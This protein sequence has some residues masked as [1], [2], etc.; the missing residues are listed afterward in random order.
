MAEADETRRDFLNRLAAG[1]WALSVAPACAPPARS[2]GFDASRLPSAEDVWDWQLWM[3]SLG[4]RYTGGEAHATFVE[5]LARSL[6]ETGL[7]VR[8]DGFRFTR[9][10]AR[11]WAL[12]VSDGSGGGMVETPVASYYP[13]SGLTP[14]GGV[15]GDLVY[16]GR[17]PDLSVPSDVAGKI[18]Y[19]ESPTPSLDFARWYAE[20]GALPGAAGLPDR[21]KSAAAQTLSA[22]DLRPFAEAGAAGVVLGWTDVSDER[23]AGQYV[24]FSRPFQGIPALWIGPTAGERLRASCA[25][26]GRA[27]LTLEGAL[28]ENTPTDTLYALAEGETDEIIIVNTHTDGPNAVE[29]NGGL[30]LLALARYLNQSPPGMMKRSVLFVLTTGHFARP[31]VPS[32]GGFVKAHPDLIERTVAALTIEHLGALAWES[33]DDVKHAAPADVEIGLAISA[34]GA[35]SALFLESAREEAFEPVVAV[36]PNHVERFFGEARQL[37]LAG[38]PAFGYIPLPEYLLAEAPHGHIDKVDKHR[39]HQE[40]RMFARMLHKLD[41]APAAA[42]RR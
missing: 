19:L 25:A 36:K 1:A 32:I 33:S 24:P 8:R 9:W 14:P 11:R 28:H 38:A 35:L 22:P 17:A 30:A 34:R 37:H 42:L 21:S 29:E 40:I 10:E 18:V 13:Y 26:G 2:S 6:E 20:V 23:A 3:N 7:T 39:L 5:F 4:P 15:E 31:Y 12:A 16:G 41:G 27:R